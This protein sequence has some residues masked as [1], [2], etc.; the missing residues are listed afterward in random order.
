MHYKLLII[1][2]IYFLGKDGFELASGERW[3]L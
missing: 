1:I 2:D 3:P